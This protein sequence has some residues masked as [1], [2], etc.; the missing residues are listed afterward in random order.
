ME[1]ASESETKGE[2]EGNFSA[3]PYQV[4][5]LERA[6]ERNTI[7]CLGTGTGKTF[8]S[9]MLIKEL[10]HEVRGNYKDGGRRTFFLVNTVPL[11]SQQA[12]AIAKHTDLKVKHYVGEMGVDFWDKP[13]WEKEFNTCNVLVMTAQIFLDL[14]LHSYILLSQVNLLIFDECH[15]A[16]KNDPYRQIM[17][18][19]SDCPERRLP[20]VMGLTASIVNGKVKP[21][22]IESEI[23]ELERTLRSTCETSQD[24]DVVRYAAK[25]EELIL[26]YPNQSTDENVKTLIQ[27]LSDVLKPGIS[28][29]CDCRVSQRENENAHWYAKFAL[30]ECKETLDELGPWAAFRVAQ[31]LIDDLDRA[32]R[33][34]SSK[35]GRMFC[36]FSATQLRQL[37]GI[38]CNFTE[39]DG[40]EDSGHCSFMPKLQ[41]LL[42]VFREF[43]DSQQYEASD[44]E[45]TLCAIVFVE[46]RYTALILSQ[47]LNM[48]AKLDRELSFIKSNFVIGHG[49]GARVNYSSNTDMN[50][51]K[52]EEVLGRFR[53]EKKRHEFNVLIATSVVEEGLDI[54][55]CNVVCRFD[56]PKKYR[57]YVQSKGRARAKGSRYYML[58]DE[59]EQ[60][61]KRNELEMLRAIEEILLERCHG[62]LEPTEEE[63]NESVD[64]DP[65]PPYIP[66]NGKG[67]RVTMSSSVSLLSMYCS[68]LPRD[69]FTAP[70][71]V[72]K[73]EE[74]GKD[75]Y[76]CKLT[77]PI[78]CQLREDIIGEPMLS[79]NQAKMAAALKAW[80]MLHK[81]G[82]LD[83]DLLP[84]RTVSDEES[85]LEENAAAESGGKPKAGTKKRRRRYKR[86][87]PEVFVGSL[88]QDG[89][90]QF[91]TTITIQVTKLTQPQEFVIS[92]RLFPGK[93]CTFG[94]LTNKRVPWVPEVFVGSLVQDGQPQF[95]TTITIQV[96]KL[97]QP[98][99]FVISERL[100]PGKTCT[101]GML[102]NKRVPWIRSFKLYPNY[103][104]VTVSLH[105]HRS[106]LRTN[107]TKQDLDVLREFHLFLFRHV[108]RSPVE[109]TPESRDG[110]FIVMLRASGRSV[111]FDDMKEEL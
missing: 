106:P 86:K 111:D 56:F 65:L 108:L 103:G 81:I 87:V 22:R 6:K 99:E 24:E 73:V 75:V 62:R 31:Y 36:E 110:Y 60:V 28:F 57:S 48:A 16:K 92:E 66:R 37:R 47:Q 101:F 15:H 96:T 82:E 61:E 52:Q 19:F 17:Q 44:K 41:K 69:R 93:T 64:T 104:E 46:R 1:K 80:K 33:V 21:Y 11:A 23:V 79:K 63:C 72:Y 90:P 55:K 14:L 89:Q 5:L 77:L 13:I 49:T 76:W 70:K 91:L 67:A 3:R 53:N 98:Q 10:A 40:S 50:F 26:V 45:K 97:T 25:P 58:V 107:N 42:N 7:V 18:C 84:K 38:Y 43:A 20:K 59:I 102:T 30:R 74:I 35:E 9:V 2:A 8:I 100:F 78:N 105:C 71:P 32:C 29:L 54:P 83:D 27:I 95:L 34:Q 4:E 51:K 68:K 88:V 12:K 39:S 109:F 94:M 85:E